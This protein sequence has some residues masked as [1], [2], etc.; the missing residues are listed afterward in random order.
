VV[1][2]HCHGGGNQWFV[3]NYDGTISP[4]HSSRMVWGEREGKLVLVERHDD[5]SRLGLF[6]HPY[7]R[8]L[9]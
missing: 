6:V 1:I 9:P 5:H 2:Y 7:F 4:T 8:N 3:V